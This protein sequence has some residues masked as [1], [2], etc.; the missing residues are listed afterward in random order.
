MNEQKTHKAL[1]VV[2]AVAALGFGGHWLF[3]T[4]SRGE[5]T[6]KS[7]IEGGRRTT[8]PA[9]PVMAPERNRRPHAERTVNAPDRPHR[10]REYREADPTADRKPRRRREKAVKK[11][12]ILPGC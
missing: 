12:K 1:M 5:A 3:G 10:G 7:K 9:V 2:V 6:A 11:D 4:D 8:G